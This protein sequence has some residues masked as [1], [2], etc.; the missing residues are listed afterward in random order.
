MCPRALVRTKTPDVELLDSDLD[1]GRFVAA[2]LKIL[3]CSAAGEG[4]ELQQ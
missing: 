4:E 3:P 2:E 1:F